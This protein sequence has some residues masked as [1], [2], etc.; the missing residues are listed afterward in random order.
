MPY[1]FEEYSECGHVEGTIAHVVDLR[2]DTITKPTVEMRKAMAVAEVGD[3]VFGEDPTVNELERRSAELMGKEDGIFLS[4]GTMCNIIAVMVHCNKRSV[5]FIAGDKS[6]LHLFEQG[7]PAVLAGVQSSIVT[8]NPDGTFSLE[9][10]ESKIRTSNDS[11]ETSTALIVVENTHNLCGGRVLP[12]EWLDKLAKIAA[13][14]N[15]PLHMDGA[16]IMNAVVKSKVSAKRIARDMDSVC[17]CLSKGLSCP[18][19]SVLCGSK[20]FIKQ[21][22]RFR[23]LL[24]GGMRQVG[25][26][27]AA[28]LVALDEMIDRLH[29]DHDHAYKVAKAISDLDSD[30]VRVDLSAVETN[31][32]NI[33]LDTAKISSKAFLEQLA[34]ITKTEEV[35]VKAL[36]FSPSSIR[37]VFHWEIS[38]NDVAGVIRKM[39]F[40]IKGLHV[41]RYIK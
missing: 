35:S 38:H 34:K 37:L 11:H 1:N 18:V 15:L 27:A 7:G 5:E 17:F 36:S 22:R 29:I 30:I 16:R 9:E 23:K 40:V 32:V 3:D 2:S 26:L 12:L 33:H 31:I 4:S 21:A 13:N 20:S 10:M 28:G 25:I 6:H 41:G 19:G 8:N 39:R 14:Y 24:G